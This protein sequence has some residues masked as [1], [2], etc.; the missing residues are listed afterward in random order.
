M[1][2][3]A[4]VAS[5]ES[6]LRA[7]STPERA[8]GQKRYLKSD[9]EFLGATVP[10]IRKIAKAVR[11]THP[12]LDH[13]TLM[14]LTATLWEPPVFETRLAAVELL[15]LHLPLLEAGDLP[16]VETMIRQSKTWALVDVLAATVVGDL[17]TR[18]PPLNQTLDRWATDPDFWIRRSALLAHLKPLREGGDFERFSGYADAMLEEKE[19]FIRK[20]IGWVLRDMS[21]PRPQLVAEWVG[22]RTHRMSGVTIRE[23]VKKLPPEQAESFMEA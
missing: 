7:V 4:V 14:D 9:F 15:T 13:D 5:I 1:D 2:V 10:A 23:A 22:P 19:F 12:D 6:D 21:H 11:R 18:F 20:A 8:E 17:I 3:P 16:V